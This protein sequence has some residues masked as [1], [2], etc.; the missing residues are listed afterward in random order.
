MGRGYPETSV[1]WYRKVFELPESDAS[2]RITVEFD[3]AYRD[4]MVIF[5]GFYI[6]RHGGGYD[7]FSFDLTDFAYPGKR[8]VLVVR[9]DAS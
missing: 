1:G 7:P 8:N 4:A 2:R 9:V 3:G 6:G 5:N